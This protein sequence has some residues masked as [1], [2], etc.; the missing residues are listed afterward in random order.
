MK[1]I[2]ANR[3]AR[4]L[5]IFTAIFLSISVSAQENTLSEKEILLEKRIP[6]W[7]K[8]VIKKANLMDTYIISDTINP[9]YLEADFNGD[10]FEDIA[11]YIISKTDGKSGI[12]IIHRQTNIHYIIGAGKDFGMG[13]SMPWLKIWNVH[14]DK[15]IKSFTNEKEQMTLKYPAIRIVKNDAISAYFYWT[16]KKYKTFNQLY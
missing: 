12:L 6:D 1:T 2:T 9:F 13:D 7:V 4:L 10:K 11:F 5:L 15:T 14:R 3:A 16:G 8:P